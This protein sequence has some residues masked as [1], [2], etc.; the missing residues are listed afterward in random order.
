MY[1]KLSLKHVIS[2]KLIENIAHIKDYIYTHVY[3]YMMLRL[4]IW[5]AF[6]TE[7]TFQFALTTLYVFCSHKWWVIMVL[8]STRAELWQIWIFEFQS[9]IV[10]KLQ[11]PASSLLIF[12]FP[13]TYPFTVPHHLYQ[14]CTQLIL[15]R[16]ISCQQTTTHKCKI[17]HHCTFSSLCFIQY[18]G[19]SPTF[20]LFYFCISCIWFLRAATARFSVVFQLKTPWRVSSM[21]VWSYFLK[22]TSCSLLA[23]LPQASSTH[24]FFQKRWDV[25]YKCNSNKMV[26]LGKSETGEKSKTKKEQN[27]SENRHQTE[28][29]G[30]DHQRTGMKL[31]KADILPRR[32]SWQTHRTLQK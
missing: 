30:W 21:R 17:I 5:Y 27:P 28:M 8:E 19:Y 9:I 14:L 29:F 12:F 16:T 7:S 10:S 22:V 3:V 24:L 11:K 4:G 20:V 13:G 31:P 1:H 26:S 6:S 25:C 18:L 32:A 15:E 23:F 2:L